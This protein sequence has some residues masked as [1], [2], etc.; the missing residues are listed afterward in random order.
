M[1]VN[2]VKTVS[3]VKI[4][5]QPVLDF[6]HEMQEIIGTG[7]EIR[8]LERSA[9][10]CFYQEHFLYSKNLYKIRANNH[11]LAEIGGAD[12]RRSYLYTQVKKKNPKAIEDFEKKISDYEKKTKKVPRFGISFGIVCAIMIAL[13]A[14]TVF[15]SM[16]VVS[17]ETGIL[18]VVELSD[19]LNFVPY[20]GLLMLIAV[21]MLFNKIRYKQS[22][23]KETALNQK[24]IVL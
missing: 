3:E 13:A 14:L 22:I 9:R 6:F 15:G 12:S 1:C 19:I 2:K 5:N 16:E 11:F 7:Q 4:K 18:G 10:S 17:P 8:A 21:Q 20:W 24:E 23:G